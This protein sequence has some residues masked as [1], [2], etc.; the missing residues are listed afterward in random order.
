M[1]TAAPTA[2]TPAAR[3]GAHLPRW[4]PLAA[5]TLLAA[6]LRLST[7]D[8]QSFW[9]DEAF[10][11]VH[12]LHPS[13]WATLRSVLHSENT[14]P[15]WYVLA[16]ADSRVLGTGEVALRL[17]SA[18]AGIATVPVVWAIARELGGRRAAGVCAALVAVNP[19][20]VWYSQEARAYSLFVLMAALAMLCFLRAEREPTPRHMAIFALTGSLALLSHYFALFLLIPMVLWLARER[21]TRRAALPSIGALAIVGLALLPLISAQGGHGTQ[22][23]GRWPLVER[24]EAIPQYYLTGYS[25]APLGHGIE[26]LVALAILAGLALGLWRMT[27]PSREQANAPRRGLV[28][29]LSIAACGVV[30]PI[31]M[32]AFGADYLAPRNLVAAMVPLTAVIAVM[33]VWPGTGRAGIALAATIALAFLAISLDVDLSPR[34]QRGNWRGVAKALRG[35]P[36]RRVI[37]TVELGSTPLEYYLPGLHELR[38]GSSVLVSE[39]DE[40][41]YSPL[42]ASAEE[43]PAPGFRLLARLDINGLIVYRFVSPFPRLVTEATLRAHVITLASPYV[44]VPAGSQVSS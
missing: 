7:L 5:L 13:L 10:T 19:L 16:W 39:I 40:T 28:M 31:V 15:L 3:A 33:V 17:P 25:G 18:L 26:L 23:I 4:W 36:R 38:E 37:T 24:L 1:S 9:Y 21:R 30:I 12:V 44:L 35:A 34:L 22:W 20:F 8:L 42:R 43:P 11:P 29:A 27:D 6:A 2:P 32:V 14:P 41:G